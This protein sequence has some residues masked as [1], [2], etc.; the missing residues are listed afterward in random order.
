MGPGGFEH[1]TPRAR[2]VIMDSEMIVGY[3]T[4]IEII[5][6]LIEEKEVVF[7]DMRHEVE[8]CMRSIQSALEGK[9][10]SIVCSGDPGI[11]GMA[12]LVFELLRK[13]YGDTI[14]DI[15]IEVVP[16]VPA[17]NACASSLGAP[18][19]HDF[20]SISLSDLLTPWDVIEKRVIA[21]AE[22][23]FVM[24]IYN[25]RSKNRTDQ[26]VKTK[27]IISRYRR[28]D[29]PVGIVRNAKRIE[30][31][32]TITTI[33]DMLGHNIDMQS[34]VIIGNSQTFIWNDLIVTPRGYLEKVN[35]E[36]AQ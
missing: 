11:Y 25:P 33:E 28:P 26:I 29:T 30:E 6:P 32:I 9:I 16:G 7:T 27:E 18:L 36:G 20:V 17:L 10:V 2:G 13:Q 12:G 23:D 21:A 34:T 19:M 31:E 5:K 1:L 15:D 8:R 22:A 35:G 24:V 3:K 14:P 4:Y